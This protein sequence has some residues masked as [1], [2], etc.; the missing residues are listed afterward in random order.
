MLH[1]HNLQK[2]RVVVEW[3][4]PERSRI[5]RVARAWPLLKS[6]RE[7]RAPGNRPPSAV[8]NPGQSYRSFQSANQ[9]KSNKIGLIKAFLL[10]YLFL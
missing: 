2:E 4:Q 3:V 6:L 1:L 10:S 7:L 8:L 9:V 5:G